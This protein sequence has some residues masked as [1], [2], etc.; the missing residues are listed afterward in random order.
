M[1][2][3]RLIDR[4]GAVFTPE[5]VHLDFL[6]CVG[7]LLVKVLVKKGKGG[8][9]EEGGDRNEEGLRGVIW[10]TSRAKG[11]KSWRRS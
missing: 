9:D 3:P 1:R 5:E 7:A 10:L 4:R 11:S 2:A 8:D 6:L